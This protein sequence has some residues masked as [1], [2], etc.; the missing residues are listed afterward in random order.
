[1]LGPIRT[2]AGALLDIA[3]TFV[4]LLAS[5]RYDKEA[6]EA[7]NERLGQL[8]DLRDA[9]KARIDKRTET[10]EKIGSKYSDVYVN[11]QA[12]CIA[13]SGFNL[14]MKYVRTISKA[15]FYER[16]YEGTPYPDRE[17]ILAELRDDQYLFVGD[18]NFIHSPIMP[19]SPPFTG[20]SKEMGWV[21]FD[22]YGKFKEGT[23]YGGVHLFV[24]S[25]IIS[26]HE[27]K[28]VEIDTSRHALR[29]TDSSARQNDIISI[30][31][32]KD[33]KKKRLMEE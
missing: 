25:D 20:L 28:D 11:N 12:A 26:D 21:G 9:C 4:E 7:Y 10:L 3:A 2:I 17:E 16:G 19:L 5:P 15:S 18:K 22:F 1:M 31:D 13:D 23:E 24:D 32:Y 6:V 27:L 29:G 14:V 8:K 30:G 33:L